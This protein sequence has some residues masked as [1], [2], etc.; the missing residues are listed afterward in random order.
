MMDFGRE[1]W[2][3]EP[4]AW[5]LW[6]PLIPIALAIGLVVGSALYVCL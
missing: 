6:G 3:K 2:I 4:S 5:S 1:D